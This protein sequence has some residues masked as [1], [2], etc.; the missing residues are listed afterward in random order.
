MRLIEGVSKTKSGALF[1]H[2][3]PTREEAG[4]GARDVHSAWMVKDGETCVNDR[5]EPCGSL[6]PVSWLGM[7]DWDPA[8]LG[9]GVGDG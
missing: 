3:V 1:H 6:M 8:T 5:G 2:F 4:S 7:L 9:D